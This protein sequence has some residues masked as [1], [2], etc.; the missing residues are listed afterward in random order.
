[1]LVQLMHNLSLCGSYFSVYA[2]SLALSLKYM[3]SSSYSVV[4]SYF[5]AFPEL[6]ILLNLIVKYFFHL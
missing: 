3:K 1:M 2:C 4:D 5:T 6:N